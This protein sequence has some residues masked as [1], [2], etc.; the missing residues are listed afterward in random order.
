MLE[1]PT[2]TTVHTK[3]E[4]KKIIYIYM[5]MHTL[6]QRREANVRH[7]GARSESTIYSFMTIVRQNNRAQNA[8]GKIWLNFNNEDTYKYTHT[9][10]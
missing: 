10:S 3:E 1:K 9:L 6:E 2:G 7:D 5:R 4:E 8:A